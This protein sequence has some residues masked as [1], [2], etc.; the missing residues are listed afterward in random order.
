MPNV[1]VRGHMR[2]DSD[3]DCVEDHKRILKERI[4]TLEG[5]VESLKK[6]LNDSIRAEERWVKE[7]KSLKRR[8]LIIG[9]RRAKR[10]SLVN[11]AETF[12]KE[13]ANAAQC[14]GVEALI[15]GT[16][17]ALTIE[18]EDQITTEIHQR[19]LEMMTTAQCLYPN[20]TLERIF[21]K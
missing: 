4:V 17:C 19:L 7:N 1:L 3:D 8:S 16:G 18:S 11:A 13:I 2:F 15:T 12:E 6:E 14:K 10:D 21:R 9:N 20:I 5:E